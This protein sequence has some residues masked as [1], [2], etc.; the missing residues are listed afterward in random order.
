[1]KRLYIILAGCLTLACCT[2]GGK[3]DN[4]SAA[5]SKARSTGG[6]REVVAVLDNEFF[7]Q[8]ESDSVRTYFAPVMFGLPQEETETKLYV[9]PRTG[10]SHLYQTHRNIILI[11][12]DT[13]NEVKTIKDAFAAPQT[14]TKISATDINSLNELMDKSSADILKRFHDGD[15]AFLQE[16]S[17]RIAHKKLDQI[18][19]MG[20]SLT[21]PNYYRPV[22]IE[23][24]FIWLLKDVKKGKH[25]GTVNILI[26]KYDSGGNAVDPI[27]L[28]DE[29]TKKYVPGPSD[30]S[31]MTTEKSVFYPMSEQTE[32]DGQFAIETRGLWRTE[33]DFMGG[34]FINYTVYDDKS[35]IVYGIDG[36]VYFPSQD[37][38][39][40]IFELE[41]ILKTFKIA[42][43]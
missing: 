8:A 30:G 23:P 21:V 11:E 24:D 40:Y 7:S 16:K 33:N 35:D 42:G 6:A 15:I 25:L 29:T 22:R 43:R 9:I 27:I 31:Y 5:A 36:F 26:Y 2:S 41:S 12:K 18:R 37:K 20:V 19:D 28:L 14:L 39:H 32:L 10:F 4:G 38:A 34:P 13:V 3:N 1:M 17:A